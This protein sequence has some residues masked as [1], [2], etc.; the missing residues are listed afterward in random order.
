M[1][2]A[3]FV[4]DNGPEFAGFHQPML[5]WN[6]W[7]CPFFTTETMKAIQQWVNATEDCMRY[8]EATDTFSLVLD[9]S[10]EPVA[11]IKHEDG[12]VLHGI[13]GWT[14]EVVDQYTDTET[15]GSRL[16]DEWRKLIRDNVNQPHAEGDVLEW[17]HT[18]ACGV[19]ILRIARL[20][21]YVAT[22]WPDVGGE[23]VKS[24]L[25]QMCVICWG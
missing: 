16:N 17:G 21:D 3:T 19:E 7:A 8:D 23:V 22:E 24:A 14:W 13:D 11:K 4:I 2:P 18:S 15:V 1:K 10:V 9:D 20:A 6:G 12:T 25:N 5:V